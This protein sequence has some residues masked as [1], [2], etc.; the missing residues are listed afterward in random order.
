MMRDVA[1]ALLVGEYDDKGAG[2]LT[3]QT[4]S[5]TPMRPRYEHGSGW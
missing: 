5:D 2:G 3:R 1:G 4:R